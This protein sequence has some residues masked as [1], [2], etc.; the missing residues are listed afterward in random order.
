MADHDKWEKHSD[1]KH[2]RDFSE[3]YSHSTV[4]TIHSIVYQLAQPT[5]FRQTLQDL[6]K[7]SCISPL[8][9]WAAP[10][11]TSSPDYGPYSPR[12]KR[13]SDMV[14]HL[15]WCNSTYI[16]ETYEAVYLNKMC[17]GWIV[18]LSEFFFHTGDIAS[19]RAM[20]LRPQ[21]VNLWMFLGLAGGLCQGVRL[22]FL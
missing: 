18:P 9:G 6:I 14:M 21:K 22:V 1:Q 4:C 7:V 13:M 8:S 10:G 17:E 12:N 3:M 11:E 15:T 5:G 2:D 20:I 19:Q 16:A